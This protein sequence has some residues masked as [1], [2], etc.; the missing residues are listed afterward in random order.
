MCHVGL[1]LDAAQIAQE[2]WASGSHVF[3]WCHPA[4]PTMQTATK[5]GADGMVLRLKPIAHHVGHLVEDSKGSPNPLLERD[6]E[7]VVRV[8]PQW[9]GQ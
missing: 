1:R 2:N 6:G 3:L 5:A 4:R 9:C 8:M 7:Q